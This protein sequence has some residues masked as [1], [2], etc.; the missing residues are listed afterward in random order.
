MGF[1]HSRIAIDIFLLKRVICLV[2]MF[3]LLIWLLWWSMPDRLE[4]LF[5]LGRSVPDLQTERHLHISLGQTFTF[6]SDNVILNSSCIS[7]LLAD[8]WMG[9]RRQNK[10]LRDNLR[11]SASS[12]CGKLHGMAWPL[13]DKRLG[14]WRA[15]EIAS[16][17]LPIDTKTCTSVFLWSAYEDRNLL[18]LAEIHES[19]RDASLPGNL[20]TLVCLMGVGISRIKRVH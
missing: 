10:A 3:R 11:W 9:K 2:F 15:W 12:C 17:S 5:V 7:F 13:V 20:R 14:G 1:K 16:Y 6:E 18:F 19:L 8:L 4:W